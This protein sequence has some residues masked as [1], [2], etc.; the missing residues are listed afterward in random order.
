VPTNEI[1]GFGYDPI[2][3]AQ[4]FLVVI[5]KKKDSNVAIYERYVWDNAT[6][7]TTG[8]PGDNPKA[9]VFISREK[10]DLVKPA[11]ED[12]LNRTLKATKRKTSRFIIGQT[13]IER[14][15]GK[16]IMVLLWAI[17]DCDKLAIPNAIQNWQGFSREEKWWLFTMTNAV[18]GDADYK[19][20]WRIAL[21]YAITDNPVIERKLQPDLFEGL[22]NH[23]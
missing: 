21:R 20:G 2:E 18:T 5:P 22:L 16:E 19:R 14:L 12:Y 17:E 23:T 6:E 11:I 15:L 1:L 9:K 7:Q 3:C 13:P 4:H 8:L 10:W